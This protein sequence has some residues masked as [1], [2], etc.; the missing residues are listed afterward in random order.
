MAPESLP[1]SPSSDSDLTDLQIHLSGSHQRAH[2]LDAVGRG[3]EIVAPVQQ[4]HALGDRMKV[5]RPVERGIAAADDQDVLVAELLHLAHGVEHRGAFIGLD[6]RH[7]RAL[8]LKRSAA[9]GDHHHLAFEHLAG[10]GGH[11]KAGI[12]DL[13]DRLHHLVEME[14]R[15]E[16]LDLLQQRIGQALAGDEG[17]AG[18]VVDRLFRIELGALAADLVEDVDQMRLH[19][20]EAQFE[21]GEQAARARA[22]DQHVGFDRF[23]HVSFFSVEPGGKAATV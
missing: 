10:I 3:A 11:A 4:R 20:Q 18:N 17:D 2:L 6:A 13:L 22:N 8:R 5:E 7:R 16:R 9:R 19:V 23:A 15:V 12:A 14:G 21:N 1:P